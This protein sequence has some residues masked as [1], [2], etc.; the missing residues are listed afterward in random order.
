MQVITS[1]GQDSGGSRKF[2]NPFRPEGPLSQEAAT[3]VSALKA[4]QLGGLGGGAGEELQGGR[5]ETGEPGQQT[6]YRLH[7]SGGSA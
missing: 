6:R 1:A 5:G 2:E 3:I 7:T 4:G